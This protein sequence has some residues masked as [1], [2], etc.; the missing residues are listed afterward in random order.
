MQKALF[1][2]FIKNQCTPEE[3]DE[4]IKW[5]EGAAG[6]IDGRA[7]LKQI[8]NDTDD[9]EETNQIDFERILDKVH[10]TL[11]IIHSGKIYSDTAPDPSRKIQKKTFIRF[12]TKV[13]A[14]LFIPLL[15]FTIYTSIRDSST[16]PR[17][18]EYQPVYT[19]ITSPYGSTIFLE[20]PDGSKV[21]LNHGSRLKFPQTFSGPTRKVELSGE[22]Y[23]QVAHNPQKPFF[24]EANE[25]QILA[26]GTEFNVMAYPDDQVIATTLKSGKIILQKETNDS[27]IHR[28]LE[29][30][31]NQHS[32]YY[33]K[34]KTLTY[35]DENP[36][37]YISWMDGKLIFRNDSLDFVIKKLSRWYNVDIRIKD[38]E[39]SRFTYTATF[40][41][42]TLPQILD[43]LKIATPI[44]YTISSRI[45]QKDG[46][47]SKRK[48]VISLKK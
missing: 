40:V 10:H 5:F 29:M 38:P 46:T 19:E 20:L 6:T 37:K 27:K 47:F 8:W 16:L 36:D 41:D 35:L 26:T 9:P 21:W 30:N 28:I 7:F 43:L 4:V 45:K 17:L 48:V 11:N 42:E 39:L 1:I 3:L 23:F 31:P 18:S 2:R 33:K 32:I 34:E 12:L 44:N 24:V 25:I 14:I 13:A 22:G 15:S